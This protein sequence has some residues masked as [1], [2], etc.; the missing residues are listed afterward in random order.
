[1][2]KKLWLL[3]SIPLF[4]FGIQACTV[5]ELGTPEAPEFLTKIK[6]DLLSKAFSV[7]SELN[8]QTAPSDSIYFITDKNNVVM[9]IERESSSS[10]EIFGEIETDSNPTESKVGI[11]DV[12]V[13]SSSNDTITFLESNIIPDSV[14]TN[15][16]TN[17]PTSQQ[18]DTL[19][20]S[21]LGIIGETYDF[22]SIP[23]ENE[24]QD[25]NKIVIVESSKDDT[26]KLKNNFTNP[27]EIK[28]L[29]FWT[30]DFS[31]TQFVA[32]KKSNINEIVQPGNTL[33]LPHRFENQTLWRIYSVALTGS[34]LVQNDSTY[35][36]ELDNFVSIEVQQETEYKVSEVDSVLITNSEDLKVDP[37]S[38]SIA[39]YEAN[40]PFDPIN[41]NANAMIIECAF[42]DTLII[43]L[44]IEMDSNLVDILADTAFV[45]SFEELYERPGNIFSK[46]EI[47]SIDLS[48]PFRKVV[49]KSEIGQRLN[50]VLEK[51][52][53]RFDNPPEF[54]QKDQSLSLNIDYNLALQ[55]SQ[56]I[57]I[58]SSDGV[59]VKVDGPV[60]VIYANESFLEGKISDYTDSTIVKQQVSYPDEIKDK[61]IAFE[62]SNLGINIEIPNTR[63]SGYADLI[64]RG[65]KDLPGGE[66]DTISTK[67]SD[68][69][70]IYF[71]PHPS[72]NKSISDSFIK[73]WRDLAS[74]INKYPENLEFIVDLHIGNK[75]S[76]DDFILDGEKLVTNAK[77]DLQLPMNISLTKSL[78]FNEVD[79]NDPNSFSEFDVSESS[80]DFINGQLQ[81]IE[82]AIELKNDL[83]LKMN[84]YIFMD[85]SR[86]NLV[87]N[88]NSIKNL[89]TNEV[90]F[91]DSTKFITLLDSLEKINAVKS[92]TS[93]FPSSSIKDTIALNG[94]EIPTSSNYKDFYYPPFTTQT[95][96]T[97]KIFV[98]ALPELVRFTGKYNS[99]PKDA[100]LRANI[101]LLFDLVID[102]RIDNH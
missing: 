50:L 5:P 87:S 9:S 23:V 3:L 69:S 43:P 27:L 77:I 52:I 8:D 42:F 90:S 98:A 46:L 47:C 74:V 13:S 96:E 75:N 48:T 78:F 40:A 19:R 1:M 38:D 85:T 58:K 37:I 76:G 6:I 65:I 22:E 51:V 45:I 94:F 97:N 81:N 24:F 88:F 91:G 29:T 14:Q 30:T 32:F 33:D 18:Q 17:F 20:F 70:R 7:L 39:I 82:L 2:T 55:D 11:F 49:L 12:T 16:N 25:F 63:L 54:K 34:Y 66:K 83:P 28:E 35:G 71:A 92:I 10:L 26:I 93:I 86:Q 41:P 57:S 56:Y 31:G 62:T 21:T 80:V 15:I 59:T 53:M 44:K 79:V 61:G 36:Q 73:N 68:K 89:V 101:N 99:I 95:N 72:Q 60:K 67:L 102:R 100:V 84:F 4:L 64:A